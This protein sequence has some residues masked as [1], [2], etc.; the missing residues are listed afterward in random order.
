MDPL[1]MLFFSVVIM[2]ACFL[3]EG[4]LAPPYILPRPQDAISIWT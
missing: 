1:R 2:D 3:A 4:P